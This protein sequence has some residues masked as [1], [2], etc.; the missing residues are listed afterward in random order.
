MPKDM[1]VDNF[2]SLP[3]G[4]AAL[5]K[6]NVT[7]KNFRFYSSETLD[8]DK[9]RKLRRMR[10][11]GA[12]FRPAL[13]G[14]SKG[15]LTIMVANTIQTATIEQSDIIRETFYLQESN[16]NL[17][18]HMTFWAGGYHTDLARARG[19]T[20]KSALSHHQGRPTDIP[21][22]AAYV[23]SHSR[24]VVDFQFLGEAHR[25]SEATKGKVCLQH[26]PS[27]Y[28]GND[29]YFLRNDRKSTSSNLD[30]ACQFSLTEAQSIIDSHPSGMFIMWPHAYLK[31]KS[32]LAADART[33]DIK[34]ALDA[35]RF[36]MLQLEAEEPRNDHMLAHEGG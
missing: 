8:L 33:M 20:W 35:E 2:A 9:P 5:K 3:F 14:P 10:L 22:P 27:R 24:P 34:E 15:R 19:F 16:T 17:G 11:K 12:I 36:A 25:A 31:S 4:Q 29:I 13:S 30:E 23:H 7:S 1:T 26:K 32:R 21:W 28:D 6:L 18:S